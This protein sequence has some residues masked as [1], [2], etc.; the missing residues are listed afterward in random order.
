MGTLLISKIREEYPGIC[1]LLRL[2]LTLSVLTP[3]CLSCFCAG[4]LTDNRVVLQTV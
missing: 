3:S 2:V 4:S 1:D